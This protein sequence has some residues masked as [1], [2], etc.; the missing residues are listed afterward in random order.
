MDT[1]LYQTGVP[2]TRIVQVL[3]KIR[4]EWETVARGDSLTEIDGN[5]GL[6]L[7][8]IAIN[9]GL[10]GLDLRVALGSLADEVLEILD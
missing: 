7:F 3:M 1:H 9:L 5:V 10:E 4:H 2:K 6:L 8:D